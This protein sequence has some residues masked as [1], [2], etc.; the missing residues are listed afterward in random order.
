M[1]TTAI[2]NL[3]GGTGKTVTAINTAAILARDYAQRVLL[4]DADSQANL[5]EFVTGIVPDNR[6][7]QYGLSD[8]LRGRKGLPMQTNIRNTEILWADASLMSLD[9]SA[10]STGGSVDPMV[11]RE[12]LLGVQD[13]YDYC[14]IDCPPAFNA[15]AIAA[16]TA[17]DEVVIPMKV[18]AFGIRGMGNLTE[19]IRNMQRVNRGLE[20]AGVLPTMTYMNEKQEKAEKDLRDLLASCGVRCFQHIRRSTMVNDST[21][22]Q[23]PLIDSSPKSGACQDYRK[24]VQD[25]TRMKGGEQ[26]GV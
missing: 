23:L 18:D 16:L 19:Q 21:F 26:D 12:F 17:A 20:I 1:R 7:M 24:F 13:Q 6:L 8:V 4:V 2:M 11:L 15:A 25:L 5:S 22:E 9:V 14:L 10:A 3:K